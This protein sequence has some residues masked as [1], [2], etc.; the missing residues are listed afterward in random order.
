MYSLWFIPLYFSSYAVF[1][2]FFPFGRGR[3][4]RRAIGREGEKKESAW[5]G[6]IGERGEDGTEWKE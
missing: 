4:G 6:G 3:K 5:E 2:F 1:L